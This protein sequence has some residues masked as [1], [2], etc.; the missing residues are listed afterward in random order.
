M[1][2]NYEIP[3]VVEIDKAH[4]II[5]GAKAPG[6]LDQSNGDEFTR[7]IDPDTDIDE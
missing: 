1:K 4:N 3:E 6:S 7:V 5:L 2:N